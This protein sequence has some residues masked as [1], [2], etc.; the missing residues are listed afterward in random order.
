MAFEKVEPL[1]NFPELETRVLDLWKDRDVFERS[2]RESAD[3]PDFVFYEGPPTANGL[4]HNG[5]VLTRVMK[6]LF[7]RY[8]T[9][10]GYHVNR[11]AGWDTHGLPVEVEVEKEL[12]IQGKQAILEYGVEDFSK[13]CLDSVFRY[14]TEWEHLTERIGFWVDLNKAYVT[15]YKSYVESVWW[16]LSELFK[17]GL[18]YKGHKVVWWWA[19]GGTALSSGETGQ[20]YR[21]VDD[22]SVYVKFPLKGEDASLVVW[23]T[24]PWTLSSNMFAAV[25]GDLDY[26]YAKDSE[27]GDMLVLADGLRESMEAKLGRSL[28]VTKT[29]KGS[30]L[31]GKRYEPP[32]DIYSKD[33]AEDDERYF[34]VVAGDKSTT[35]NPQWFVTLEAGTGVV[36]LAPAFGEDDW[37]V[38][39][40]LERLHGSI[41]LLCAV[42]PDGG[43]DS[44]M[45]ENYEGI[46]VKDGD[47]KVIRELKERELVVHSEIYRHEYPFCWRSDKDPLI[48]YARDAW[49]IRTT[50]KIDRV[51]ENNQQVDWLPEHIKDGRFGDFLAGNVDW[52][53]SRERFWGTPLNIWECEECDHSAAPASCSEIEALNP[54]AFSAFH[55]AKAKDPDLK[56]H[57]MVHKPW[58]DEVTLPCE[59]C[60]GKMKRVT[61]VIDCWFDSGCM[62]FAQFG[63]PHLEGSQQQFERAF[64][65]DFISEA[66]DQTRGWFYSLMMVSNLLFDSSEAPHPYKRCIVLGHVSDKYGKKESKSSGNYTPPEVILDRVRMGFGLVKKD[67]IAAKPGEALIAFEDLEGLDISDGSTVSL[68]R[69]DEPESAIKIKLKGHKKLPRRQVVLHEDVIESLKLDYAPDDVRPAEVPSLPSEQQACLEGLG[70]PAPGADAFRWF[71]YASNPPWNNTRHSLGNVRGKQKELPLKLR[72]VYAFFVTYANI[73]RFDPVKDE[74]S[75]RPVAKRNLLDRWVMSEFESMKRAVISLMDDFKSYDAAQKLTDFVEA[76]S[77]WYV[78]RSRNR[79]WGEERDQDKMDAYWTLYTCLCDLSLFLAPFIPFQAEDIYQN[80]VVAQYGEGPKDSVHLC[81]L[82]VADLSLIDEDLSRTMNALRDLVSIGLKVRAD[83]KLKVRQPLASAEVILSD[84]SL[85]PALEPY[86]EIMAEELNV[87]AVRFSENAANYVNYRVK[88]N[89]QKLG[90]KLGQRMK[91]CAAAIRD[92]DPNQIYADLETKGTTEIVIADETLILSSEEVMVEVV[93]KEG[94]AA[95][96]SSIGVVVLDSRIDDALKAEGLFREVLS[97]I[98]NL[99]KEINLDYQ[100]RIELS[101]EGDPELIQVCQAQIENLKTETLAIDILFELPETPVNRRE[102]KIDGM[103]LTVDLEDKGVPSSSSRD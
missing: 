37:K 9:M 74:K 24:T 19:Q 22:P 79:F 41:P 32:F 51:I 49:F 39:R 34:R 27:T 14:T 40:R 7:P 5:H 47:K 33:V 20:G 89:F 2:L 87:K 80:L 6:D 78:R 103:Q 46:W 83:N 59:K 81:T 57:L 45:G 12:R 61:E 72:A 94:F 15:F 54:D 95:S 64:P 56:E 50:D 1:P 13:K 100:S 77:N 3:R 62:P 69:S 63:Y 65:A 96:G 71:F 25:H 86:V 28:E 4:P 16:A 55:E 76:L 99:R 38:W 31:I 90:K 58:I 68:Y 101:L 26:V 53:L 8:R 44:V 60:G 10:R 102:L 48:Q 23:T 67:K 17:K 84:G 82:P 93:A 97:K 73:D 75:R 92:A 98:Q 70:V 36:H 66:I 29:V 21:T 91:A 88:P 85:A 52:A 35:N 30:E 18:L 43:F 42:R 11:W